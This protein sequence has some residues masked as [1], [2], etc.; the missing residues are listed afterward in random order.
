MKMGAKQGR[1][2][3]KLERYWWLRKRGVSPSEID[4]GGSKRDGLLS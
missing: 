3:A 2:V 1:W 4:I